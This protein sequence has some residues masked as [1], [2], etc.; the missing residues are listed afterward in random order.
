[1]SLSYLENLLYTRTLPFSDIQNTIKRIGNPA[2]LEDVCMHM[3]ASVL[4]SACKGEKGLLA[5]LIAIVP[6]KFVT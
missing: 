2:Y 5:G 3:S 4:T 6:A 1:V